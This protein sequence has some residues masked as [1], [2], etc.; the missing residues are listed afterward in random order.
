[1]RL[2]STSMIK[3]TDGCIC[4]TCQQ[5]RK[6]RLPT[7]SIRAGGQITAA[8]VDVVDEKGVKHPK[9]NLADALRRAHIVKLTL[10]EINPTSDPPLCKIIDYFRGG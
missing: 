3:P 6:P 10:V 2:P 7:G 5:L 1:M 4:A 8:I 9:M